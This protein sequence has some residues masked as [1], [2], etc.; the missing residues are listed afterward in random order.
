M[1]RVLPRSTF[2]QDLAGSRVY[3]KPVNRHSLSSLTS[4]I[5][6][7]TALSLFS[8]LS[9][10]EVS[11]ISFYALPVYEFD[12]RNSGYYVFGEEGVGRG[13]IGDAN[14]VDEV[15][16]NASLAQ[17]SGTATSDQTPANI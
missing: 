6:W 11:N 8:K 17:R 4:S 2:E 14:S 3:N 5:L 15:S 13:E 7:T 1:D 12:L 16:D 9:L 10:L